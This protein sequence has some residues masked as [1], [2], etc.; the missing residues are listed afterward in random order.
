MGV[1]FRRAVY[2]FKGR[3]GA[4]SK[5]LSIPPE[6]VTENEHTGAIDYLVLSDPRGQIPE[7]VLHQWLEEV[8][9]PLRIRWLE[10]NKKKEVQV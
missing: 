4:R 6:T 9:E 10:E 7:E 3:S 1:K 5:A 8:I 2:E